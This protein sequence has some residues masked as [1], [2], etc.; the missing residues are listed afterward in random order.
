MPMNAPPWLDSQ[1]GPNSQEYAIVRCLYGPEPEH[2]A[3]DVIA[4]ALTWLGLG[5]HGFDAELAVGELATNARKHAPPPYE[6]RVYV[7]KAVV[8]I[9]IVDGGVDHSELAGRLAGTTTGQPTECESGRGLQ[10]V[11][12]LFHNRCGAELTTTCTGL[13][14]VKQVWIALSR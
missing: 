3:R 9:A 7:S 8:K 5:K 12:G 11:T 13:G 10:L 2:R 14:P 1:M 4:K 6:L